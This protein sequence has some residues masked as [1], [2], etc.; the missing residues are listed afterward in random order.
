MSSIKV[1]VRVRPFNG[2]ERD[3]KCGCCVSMS[4]A[5][6]TIHKPIYLEGKENSGKDV[7]LNSTDSDQSKSFTFDHSYWSH[8][9]DDHNYASQ[10]HVYNDIGAEMLEH[11]IQGYNVCI[12]A[13][14]QT[15][16]GKSYTMMGTK[17]EIGIIPR[18]CNE[19]FEKLH[20][21]DKDEHFSYTV[22]VSYL[23]I[24]FER[25]RDLL[26]P[27]NKESLKV[28]EHD[29]FGPY[30]ED[31][32]KLV[33]TTYK[34]VKDLIDLGNMSRT[35]AST[36]MNESSSRSHAVLTL[37]LSQGRY[38]VGSDRKGEKVSK[39]SLVDLA[40]SERADSTGA[41]GLRLREGATI[42]K[43]L[44]TLGRV[45]AALEKKS[46]QKKGK[47]PFV[48]YRESVLTWLLRENLGG[49]SKT[50][51]IAAISPADINYDET[52][53][54]LNYANRTKN[55]VCKAVVNEDANAKIIR[56]LKEEIERL[57]S[58]LQSKGINFDG[59][60]MSPAPPASNSF[61]NNNN[62]KDNSSTKPTAS[63]NATLTNNGND[64][65]DSERASN[66][67]D[68]NYHTN[69]KSNGEDEHSKAIEQLAQSEKLVLE[70]EETYE[71]K[72]K[73]SYAIKFKLTEHEKELV[74]KAAKK[75]RY[76][77]FSSIRDDL[78]N[79][80]PY[81]AEA[82][83][84]AIE[85]DKR[86]KLKFILMRE[87][88]FSPVDEK[89]LHNIPPK[90][91]QLDNYYKPTVVAVEVQDLKAGTI[92]RWPI[93]KLK[94]RLDLMKNIQDGGDGQ[95]EILTNCDA[96]DSAC[97]NDPFY[98]RH[99]WCTIIGRA[100]LYLT[101]LL[102][103][104]TV[105]QKIAVVNDSGDVKGYLRVV[106]QAVRGNE[107]LTAVPEMGSISFNI[108]RSARIKFDNQN[109]NLLRTEREIDDILDDI[110]AVRSYPSLRKSKFADDCYDIIE[111]DKKIFARYPQL[112]STIK[113]F[114]GFVNELTEEANEDDDDDES[115][116]MGC[117]KESG[118]TD[119]LN[120]R[121]ENS[122]KHLRL[123]SQFT[124]RITIL[125]AI[126][127]PKSYSD[128][129]C[130][131]SFIHQPDEVFSTEQIK[132]TRPPSGF[133]SVQNITVTNVT[134]AFINYLRTHPIVFEVFG[135]NQTHPLHREAKD[136]S[137]P[138]NI[139]DYQDD[140]K[141]GLDNK[142]GLV[143][144]FHRHIV[145]SPP[146][147]PTKL[148]LP[149]S[150]K[151]SAHVQSRFDILVWFEICELA[152]NSDEY[153]PVFVDRS[154][155][156]PYKA[157]F[158]LHQGIQRKLCITMVH[159]ED[160][161][162]VWNDVLEVLIGRIRTTPDAQTED[163][164]QNDAQSLA[165]FSGKYLKQPVD[166][167]VIYR[168][169]ANW[170]TSLHNTTLLNRITPVN[171]RVYMT[172]SV[173]VDLQGCSQPAVIT[174]DFAVMIVERDSNTSKLLNSSAVNG[175]KSFFSGVTQR[176]DRCN[177]MSSIYELSLHRAMDYSS[178]RHNPLRKMPTVSM[179]TYNLQFQSMKSTFSSINLSTLSN[180][181]ASH[182]HSSQH[183]QQPVVRQQ[184]DMSYMK[185]DPEY[186]I[187]EHQWSLEK[188]YR[189]S[190]VEKT[191]HLETVCEGLDAKL[192]N[193]A[194]MGNPRF[195][196]RGTQ[197]S[198]LP[199]SNSLFNLIAQT[200]S[201]SP[202]NASINSSTSGTVQDRR[203]SHPAFIT[204]EERNILMRFVKLMR[205]HIPTSPLAWN[206]DMNENQDE[207]SDESQNNSDASS[208]G[209]CSP[210]AHN[211]DKSWWFNKQRLNGSLTEM[212]HQS[213]SSA[214]SLLVPELEEARLS[215]VVSRRGF[216]YYRQQSEEKWFKR[217][218]VVIR[219]YLIIYSNPRE[220]VERDII[221]LTTSQIILP[222]K[223]LDIGFVFALE[224]KHRI[225]LMHL[226]TEKEFYDWIYAMNPLLA[227]QI[228]SKRLV[229]SGQADAS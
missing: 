176:S 93:E 182:K 44:T 5:S 23:E 214:K 222:E 124:F 24:Y 57:R 224:T 84:L 100:Y 1:A 54:T 152:P 185:L 201:R 221:N 47:E 140:S 165:I 7:P 137:M 62:S 161:M 88:M 192:S 207:P 90:M 111:G 133:F 136:N 162:V 184:T 46:S 180:K 195:G 118:A 183:Q 134:N 227:G 85:R 215:P 30:V 20:D 25:V 40:G 129:F 106:V 99:H 27:K 168:L 39:I 17:D 77:Q 105:V 29:V 76:Y 83:R 52:L 50:A 81:L 172:V 28:R 143:K 15:G 41:E 32:T 166:G 150:H 130:Q 187:E 101:N 42:N 211:L 10:E 194:N 218:F 159:E 70:L 206:Q 178:P 59:A 95:Q 107:E 169:E 79:N 146:V 56:G 65:E 8:R 48:P 148:P 223:D 113:T 97:T 197:R 9:K 64:K 226:D 141:I 2:R 122:N 144:R 19:L 204:L 210:P 153:N 3:L 12:F 196:V 217:W 80:A 216:L 31:L 151:V 128:V 104:I 73:R 156:E 33:V 61:F 13:Y 228:K 191:R 112:E 126:D 53:S 186:M 36:R 103:P 170:D 16:A 127:L 202:S 188:I 110:V 116:S 43:S 199:H 51:M 86:V 96:Y 132:N 189:L 163:D 94:Y 26:N 72:L 164:A 102:H 6:T 158:L 175:L 22:E 131:Y 173:Y 179:S 45:I 117:P 208:P 11:A 147:P 229:G 67:V 14:G 157:A 38:D 115:N 203:A 18:M 120:K 154:D 171:D 63:S 92:N 82:N 193:L 34:E 145:Q 139:L 49:N 198:T 68:N 98:D 89:F 123:G 205:Y 108:E 109:E 74:M 114:Q 135:Q 160:P 75:W 219:P 138:M 121:E 58:I 91:K 167:R 213:G 190:E 125:Q 60:K 69:N 177:H 181:Q 212:T 200:M 119:T 66:Q 35:T 209:N 4:G 142:G 149:I 220:Q 174:K 37:T 71:E 21:L 225:Y 155:P 87:T 55:I 78:W